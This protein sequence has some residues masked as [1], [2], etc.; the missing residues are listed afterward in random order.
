[1][2]TNLAHVP[3]HIVVLRHGSTEWAK[4]GRFTSYTD[5]DLDSEGRAVASTWAAT[6]EGVDL[7]AYCSPLLRARDTARL[8][9]LT[10]RIVD[11][12]V[13]WNLGD[14]EGLDSEEYRLAHLHWRLFVDG[15]PGGESPQE[16]VDRTQNELRRANE[17]TT[18]IC[19]LV[20]HGQIAKVVATELLKLPLTTG[21]HFALG[22]GRT[23]VFTWRESLGGYLMAGWN[24]TA[25]PLDE[26]LNGN[27]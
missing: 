1:M 7:T 10:P 26:L 22:P 14:L 19:V 9:G 17:A 24:R 4:T 21:D 8:A 6:F 16:V 15:A 27:H 25:V 11:D 23:A 18:D 12:L 13:E 5:V 3:S 2:T 20:T